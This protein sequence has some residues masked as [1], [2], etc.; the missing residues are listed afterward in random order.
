M[1]TLHFIVPLAVAVACSPLAHA[2][3]FT[4]NNLGDNGTGS[5]RDRIA[6]ANTATGA[7]HVVNFQPGL[8]GTIALNSPIRISNSMTISGPGAAVL[9]IDGQDATRLFDVRR[10][11]G[12]PRSVVINGLTMTRGLADEGGAIYAFDEDLSVGSSI[13]RFNSASQRGGA[14]F[15]AEADLTLDAVSMLA[16]TVPS[17]GQGSG[18]GIYFSAGT[19]TVARSVIAQ[20]TANFGAGLRITSPRANAVI[21]DS[22]IEDNIAAHTGGAIYAGTMTSFRMSGSAMV[23]NS[24]GE[25]QGGGIYFNG[26]SDAAAPTSVI[27]NSTFSGKVTRHQS[28]QGSALSVSGGRLLVRNSTFAFNK[29]A[30]TLT[31]TAGVK[32]GAIWVDSTNTTVTLESTLFGAN[33]QGVGSVSADLSH[34]STSTSSPGIVNAFDSLFATMPGA[35]EINGS[36]VRNQFATD[37]LLKPLTTL[38]GG[39]FVPVHPVSRLSPAIDRGSNSGG[40]TWDQRGNG[41]VRAWTDARYRNDP[42]FSKPDIGAYEHRGDGIF[43]GIF[44]QQ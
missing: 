7:P 41:F 17:T 12:N 24:T 34:V 25:P 30:P 32:A 2:T 18:G 35:A 10:T 21:T 11:S 6:Q 19:L 16:N 43:V 20:N 5:L 1:R 40:L 9:T 36:N 38:D 29:C 28:G 14:I 23:A 39:G 33:T 44:E 15:A 13:F 8:T 37:A 27:E 26:S 31:P 3:T 22:L 42:V 4:V